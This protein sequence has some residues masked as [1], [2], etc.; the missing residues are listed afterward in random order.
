MPPQIIS[1]PLI[2]VSFSKPSWPRSLSFDAMVKEY[3]ITV[4]MYILHL[5]T[6]LLTSVDIKADSGG[7]TSYSF[8]I[9]FG[10]NVVVQG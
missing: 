10:I 9:L 6:M 5:S 4:S 3:Y 8:I 2:F 1:L 7:L